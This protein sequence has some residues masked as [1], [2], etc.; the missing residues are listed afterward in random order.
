MTEPRI[1]AEILPAVLHAAA[2]ISE[3]LGYRNIGAERA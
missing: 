1:K 3:R 2:G